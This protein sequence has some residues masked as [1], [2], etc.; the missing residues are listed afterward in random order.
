MRL[1]L[2]NKCFCFFLFKSP[3]LTIGRGTSVASNGDTVLIAPGTYF[4]N[5]VSSDVDLHIASYYLTSG[6][7]SY[8]DTTIID[9][10][11]NGSGIWVNSS[12]NQYRASNVKLSGLTISN[13]SYG[14][15]GYNDGSGVRADNVESLTLDNLNG[16][17]IASIFF[18]ML[19]A[20]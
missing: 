19:L 4:E 15:N 9:A 6:D 13:A 3:F 11:Q 20:F 1:T 18:I 2:K 12:S 5:I 10:Q 7:R 17:I 14:S 16:F 8:I